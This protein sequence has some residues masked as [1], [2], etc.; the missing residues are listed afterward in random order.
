MPWFLKNGM[1]VSCKDIIFVFLFAIKI[2]DETVSNARHIG[3]ED[4]KGMLSK[5]QVWKKIYVT[6][7]INP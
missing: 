4:I 5:M 3:D 7:W 2:D 1:L 6:Q